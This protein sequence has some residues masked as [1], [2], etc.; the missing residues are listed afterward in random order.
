MKKL[1]ILAV[2]FA[3]V[4]C[5]AACGSSETADTEEATEAEETTEAEEIVH[6][7]KVIMFRLVMVTKMEKFSTILKMVMLKEYHLISI[8]IKKR[9]EFI[10]LL[11][12]L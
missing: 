9:R 7:N 3:M 8:K 1:L 2:A 12:L 10:S 4:F 6:K 5:F 11:F